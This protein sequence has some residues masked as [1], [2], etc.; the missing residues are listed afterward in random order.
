[1]TKHGM[2]VAVTAPVRAMSELSM[3]RCRNLNST[4]Y[5]IEAGRVPQ[6]GERPPRRRDQRKSHGGI[7][8]AIP[9]GNREA[10]KDSNAA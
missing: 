4:R 1:M 7:Q 10:L 8:E 3:E 2:P 6:G 9:L 5:E